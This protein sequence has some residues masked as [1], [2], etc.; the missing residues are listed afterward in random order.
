VAEEELVKPGEEAAESCPTEETRSSGDSTVV[1]TGRPEA[2]HSTSEAAATTKDCGLK[3][4]KRALPGFQ[5]SLLEGAGAPGLA[6]KI[7]VV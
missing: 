4:Q 1:A 7:S 2:K 6:M 5:P 3:C